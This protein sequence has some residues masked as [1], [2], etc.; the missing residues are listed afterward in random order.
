MTTPTLQP[1][2]AG[3]NA[4]TFTALASLATSS[5]FVAGAEPQAPTSNNTSL[6]SDAKASGIIFVGTT[7]TIN[8]AIQIYV[9]EA[10]D[11]TPTW[12]DVFDGTD[13]V[14]TL[15]SVGVGAGF[16]KLGAVLNV[17]STTSDRGYP[18]AFTIERLFGYLPR[19]V[20]FFV[21]HNTGVNLKSASHV[22]KY[23]GFNW[24]LPSI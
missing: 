18:F 9:F 5:T 22:F 21:T 11:A 15:T 19:D 3:F 10:L 17:D 24:A 6:F 1:V 4:L 16:L 8:T 12:P 14:E 7:P 20:S 2:Y 23:S 13:S